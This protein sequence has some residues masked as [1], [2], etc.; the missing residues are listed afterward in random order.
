MVVCR[1]L[2][3]LPDIVDAVSDKLTVM[4]DSGVRTVAHA[5]KALS[6]GKSRS[7]RKTCYFKW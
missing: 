2:D 4:F 5:I 6:W 7:G 1:S 3:A